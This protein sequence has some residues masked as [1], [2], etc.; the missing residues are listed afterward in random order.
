MTEKTLKQ[1]LSLLS[2]STLIE[3]CR[4]QVSDLART[5]GKSHK[6]S[7]PPQKEDTDIILTEMLDR[8][9]TMLMLEKFS[10]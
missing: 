5:Y 10:E 1:E 7:I 3:K 4:K 9:E 6:M 8:F 2:D